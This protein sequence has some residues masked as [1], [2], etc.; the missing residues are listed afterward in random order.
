MLLCL[1]EGYPFVFG[2][3][4]YK[5]FETAKVAKTGIVEMPSLM[6]RWFGGCLGGHAVCAV[7]YNRITKRFLVRNSWGS[8]WGQEGYFTIPFSYLEKYGSDFWTIRK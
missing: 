1:A 5:S 7:G 2:I 4:I 6:E 8:N 3:M